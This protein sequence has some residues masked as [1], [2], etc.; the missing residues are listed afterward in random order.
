VAFHKSVELVEVDWFEE[1]E[2]TYDDYLAD[3]SAELHD[4][5]KNKRFAACLAPSSYVASQRLA[6]RLLDA[7]SLGMIYPS[8]RRDSGTCLACFRPALVMNV[9]KGK[10]YKFTQRFLLSQASNGFGSSSKIGTGSDLTDRGPNARVQ[11]SVT[12]R[13]FGPLRTR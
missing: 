6:Q 12:G 13:T 2:G 3:F 10:T 5:R 7:G 1:E 11:R 9:R 4:I 8:V